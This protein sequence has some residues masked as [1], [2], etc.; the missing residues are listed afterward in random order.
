M[1]F[2]EDTQAGFAVA[3]PLNRDVQTQGDDDP[4]VY[5]NLSHRF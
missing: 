2:T 1:D 5:F 3:F 4:K